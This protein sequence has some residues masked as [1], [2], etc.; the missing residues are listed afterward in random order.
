[1]MEWSHRGGRIIAVTNQGGIERGFVTQRNVR[2]ALDRTQ[3]LAGGLFD[4]MAF[5]PHWGDHCWCRKPQPG[6]VYEALS[7]LALNFPDEVYP[8][9]QALVVGDRFED[10]GLAVALGVTFRQADDWRAGK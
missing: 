8:R 10:E 9:Q 3:E 5:C 7:Q 1:M 2:L 4:V 6:M